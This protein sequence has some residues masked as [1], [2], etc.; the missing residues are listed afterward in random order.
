MKDKQLDADI[1]QYVAPV[2]HWEAPLDFTQV[3]GGDLQP[4]RGVGDIFWPQDEFL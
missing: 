2:C 1:S 4:S 3:F